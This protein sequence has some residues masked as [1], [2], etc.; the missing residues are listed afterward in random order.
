[1]EQA[2]S[3]TSEYNCFRYQTFSQPNLTSI[4]RVAPM[5][6][7]ISNNFYHLFFKIRNSGHYQ[8]LLEFCFEEVYIL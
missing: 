7:L 3:K 2:T 5:P 4:V 6:S 8:K 1:M